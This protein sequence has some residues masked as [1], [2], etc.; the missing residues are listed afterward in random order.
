MKCPNRRGERR[1]ELVSF[2][3]SRGYSR[4]LD[5]TSPES[6]TPPKA[7]EGT[8]SLVLDHV[9]RVAYVARSERSDEGLAQR[10]ASEL[11]FT[12]VVA[13]DA[14][15]DAGTPIYHTNVLMAV[16]TG[17]AVVCSEAVE[18][19][20]QRGGLLASL[21]RGGREVVQISRAQMGA[22]AGNVLEASF[23]VFCFFESFFNL[24]C[25]CSTA[26]AAPALP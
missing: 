9:L 7:L 15:D 6:S 3:K 26:T 20:E 23:F 8:G 21:S 1:P 11:S 14:T 22:F 5:L 25:R 18:D 19:A 24:Y 16:G 2:L 17:W 10:A 13:F 12:E 4:F